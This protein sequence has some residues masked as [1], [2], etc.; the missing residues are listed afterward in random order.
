MALLEI[1]KAGDPVLKQVC[2]PVDKV[3][4]K[5]RKLMESMAE[6]MYKAEGVG[7]AAPQIGQSIRVVVIDVDDEN[8]LLEM[9]NPVI[10]KGEG[11]AVDQEGCLS[12]PNIFGNVE[13]FEKVTAEYT[14]KWGKKKRI[15]AKGLLAR[16]I[17]HELDHLEGTLFI[18][19]A[20]SIRQG[21]KK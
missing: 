20:K 6:T 18:D 17:Q 10:V 12:V 2:T 13:R 7:L 5:L 15:N 3:D 4:S 14:N 21:D 9:V 8:G 11:T 1:V 19:K 16:C